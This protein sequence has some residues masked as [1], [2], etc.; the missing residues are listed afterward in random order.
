[1]KKITLLFFLLTISIGYSQTIPVDFES[2]VTVGVNWNSDSGLGSV[3]IVTDPDPTPSSRGN[4]G[5]INGSDAGAVWQNAQLTLTT[6]YIDLTDA[7]GSNTITFDYYSTVAGGGLLKLEQSLNG[8]GNVERAFTTAGTGWEAIAVDLDVP[9]VGSPVNDQYKLVVIFPGIGNGNGASNEV[10]YVHNISGTVGDAIAPPAGDPAT[11]APTPTNDNSDVISVYSDT[12]TSIATNLNPGWGQATTMTE[13]QI[14]G[15]NTMKYANLN[16]QGLEYT[17]TDVSAMEYIHLDYYTDDATD[18]DFYLIAGGENAYDIDVQLG[19][20]T[21]QWVS[22][23]IELSTAYPDRD[24]ANAFQFKT[25]G[26]GTIYLD[27]LYFW[28]TPPASGTDASLSDLQIDGA[29]ITGFSS[30]TI[31]YTYELVA[32]TT[33]APII[34]SVTPTDPAATSAVI[35]NATGVPGDATVLVTSQNGSVTETYTVSF[36]ATIPNPS[37]TPSTPNGEVLSV[38]GDT[39]GFTNIWTP[40]YVFGSFVGKPD[41]DPTAGVN[42]AIKMDF[43]IAGYGEG[44]DVTS[45]ISSNNWVHFDYFAPDL[46]AGVNGHQV[47]FILIGGGEFNYEMTIGG[48]DGTLVLGSWQSVNVPLSV[49]EAKGFSKTNFHQFKLGSE[50]DLNTTIVYFDN[51]YFSVNE[52]THLGTKNYEI[53]GLNAYPNPTINSWNISTENETINSIEIFNVLG[54]SVISL[55]PNSREVTIDASNLA[56]GMYFSII[57]TDAGASTRKLIKK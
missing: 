57:S 3:A 44:T 54:K 6:N 41:L 24:L 13:I 19:I 39:G 21:G 51:I 9:D 7:T 29:T 47:R 8:G 1:M 50:S 43:S 27:N 32:G 5:Q 20:T 17:N 2:D 14:S 28:K 12:Y 45:D 25:V 56:T 37:P 11:A 4:V 34:T 48:S 46:P 55:K 31:N 15:N 42:E 33:V 18:F 40:D 26:N 36:V 22:I 23:D 30:N 38:Y 16:Y 52:G 53:E 35:T 49:F 10:T